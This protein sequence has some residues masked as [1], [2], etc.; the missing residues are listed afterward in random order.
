MKK[1]ISLFLFFISI[2]IYAQRDSLQVGDVY[3]EDQLY[4]NVSYNIFD[5]QPKELNKSGFSFGFS[6]GYIKDVPLAK[7]GRVALG[8]GLGYGFDSFNH[9]LKV[10]KGNPNSFEIGNS[11]SSN[12]LKIHNIEMPIQFRWRTSAVNTYSFWRVYTGIKLSYNFNH[13]FKYTDAGTQ[14]S[15]SNLSAYNK[16]QTGFIISAGYG[17]FNFHLYYGLTPVFKSAALNGDD[18]N[19]NVIR[20]G[21]SFYLL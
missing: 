19:T 12:K 18:I 15:I 9:N 17:T 13:T 11:L 16:F 10:I 1:S 5:K 14:I 4:I 7:S 21:L 6:G 2:T 3:W 20:F 8:I